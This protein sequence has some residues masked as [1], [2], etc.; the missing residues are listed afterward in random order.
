MNLRHQVELLTAGFN[1]V[2]TCCVI[3]DQ[4]WRIVMNNSSAE[5]L[6]AQHCGSEQIEN[7]RALIPNET[8]FKEVYDKISSG[9]ALKFQLLDEQFNPSPIKPAWMANFEP[10]SSESED[11]TL[12]IVTIIDFRTRG[13]ELEQRR[14]AEAEFRAIFDNAFHFLALLSTEG[15]IIQAN[16]AALDLLEVPS[17]T[18]LSDTKFVDAPFFTKE[19]AKKIQLAVDTALQKEIFRD[20]VTVH[21]LSGKLIYVDSVFCP[22]LDEHGHIEYILAEGIDITE[23]LAAEEERE[24]LRVQIQHA[25]KLESLGMLAGGIAH[26]FNNLL[27]G[28]LGHADLAS[29]KLP[30]GSLALNNLKEIESTARIAADLCRQMLAYSGKGK[31]VV[32]PIDLNSVISEMEQLLAISTSKNTVLKFQFSEELPLMEG[33]ASQISQI[34]LNLVMN[35]SEAIG[36]KSGIISITT[37]AMYCDTNYFRTNQVD[38]N[39]EPGT[40]L[41]L[42]IADTGSGMDPETVERIFDPF[43]ST[44]FTGRGLGLAAVLGIVKGHSGNIKVYSEPGKGTTFKLLFPISKNHVLESIRDNDIQLE[45]KWRGEGTILIVDDEETILA[46]AREMLLL[47]GFEVISARDGFEAI[48]LYQQSSTD[49]DCVLLDLTMPRM[50][51]EATFRELRRL[52]PQLKIIMSSGYNEQEV[53]QNFVGKGLTGFIQKP[54]QLSELKLKLKEILSPLEE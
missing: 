32:Q 18:D 12:V 47:C 23:R 17:H 28:I 10:I 31:F 45:D 7:L 24:Q 14:R 43:F 37:G 51:G 44:K 16:R 13:E 8:M 21:T 15:N 11:K 50:G 20:V 48:K 29:L 22:I 19:D 52:N 34:I 3:T 33:D 35:A 27:M 26:D 30:A 1:S 49:I 41:Y 38:F 42:E 36:T 46:I 4:D 2:A 53:T 39:T 5:R 40:Y 6:F 54:Y 9:K 25:Q